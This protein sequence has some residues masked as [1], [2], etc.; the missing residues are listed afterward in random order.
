MAETAEPCTT[1]ARRRRHYSTNLC[2]QIWAPGRTGDALCGERHVGD[3]DRLNEWQSGLR[4]HTVITD[5]PVCGR[6]ARQPAAQAAI[7]TSKA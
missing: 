1:M 7:G 3:Q 4:R 2:P 5:L 6:C